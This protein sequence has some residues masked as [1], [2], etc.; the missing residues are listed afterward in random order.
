MFDVV[1]IGGNLAGT[2]AA[3]N[4]AKE[5]INVAL[6]ERNKEP[7]YPAHCGEMLTNVETQLLELDRIG[8]K[9]NE[10]NKIVI[11]ISSKEYIFV[12]F[13]FL[14]IILI[15]NI[16]KFYSKLDPLSSYFCSALFC[17]ALVLFNAIIQVL[18][19]FFYSPLQIRL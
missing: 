8:C 6:I 2:T 17:N 18:Y 16:N 9:K 19:R 5:G 10:I 15:I 3:I 14:I 4:A 1:V 11:N 13:M 7:F 12:K